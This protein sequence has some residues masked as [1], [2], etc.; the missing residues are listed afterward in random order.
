MRHRV[1]AGLL[2]GAI[3]L[4]FGKDASAATLDL[5]SLIA[6]PSFDAAS[7]P[8]A[9]I[10]QNLNHDQYVAID[11]GVVPEPATGLLVGLGLVF[12]SRRNRC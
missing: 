4:S 5:A 3:L 9:L 2:L 7:V 10:G 1:P 8:V 6:N 12:L 11:V